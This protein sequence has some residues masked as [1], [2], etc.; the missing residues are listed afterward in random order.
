MK[1]RDPAL[2]FLN[3]RMLAAIYFG[4]LSVAATLLIN[5]FLSFL[6]FKEII[7][8]FA[9]VLVGM[10]VASCSGALF[11]EKIIYCKKPYK[12]K[13]FLTGF[14]MVMASLPFFVLGLLLFIKE[15][16]TL[17][18]IASLPNM[19]YTYLFFLLYSY[20]IFGFFLAIAAGFAAMYLR[21]QIVYDILNTHKRR[22][23]SKKHDLEHDKEHIVHR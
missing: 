17:F 10:V 9:S 12:I 15:P 22:R 11:G 3:P 13:T 14:L 16:V 6:G 8:I 23:R 5:A 19:I 18:S 21:G 4:L 2:T 7:P 1:H 20:F